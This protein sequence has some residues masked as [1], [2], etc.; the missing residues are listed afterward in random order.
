MPLLGTACHTATLER[1][2]DLAYR[3]Y[4][5]ADVEMLV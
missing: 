4:A 1:H 5:L 2:F 3:G